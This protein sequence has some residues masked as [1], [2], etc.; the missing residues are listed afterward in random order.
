MVA[1]WIYEENLKPLL[2]TVSG[3]VA[4]SF[5][6]SDWVA[7]STGSLNTSDEKNEWYEYR[8]IGSQTVDVKIA[9]DPGSCVVFVQL[10]GEPGIE[11]KIEVAI[12]IFQQY[13][14]TSGVNANRSRGD[15]DKRTARKML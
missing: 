2:E 1:D 4:Y 6:E 5:D 9:A 12:S 11:E 13:E 3:F 15:S 7:V 10:Q 8:L 14:V